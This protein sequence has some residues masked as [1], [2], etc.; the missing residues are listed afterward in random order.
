MTKSKSVRAWPEPQKISESDY[1]AALVPL[2]IKLVDLQ[3]EAMKKG[4]KVAIVFEGRDSAGK[5]GVIKRITEHLSLRQTRVIALP[6]PSDREK[7]QWWFQR[8][9]GHLPAA[10][11]I[12]I[13]NRSWYNRA[14]VERVMGFSTEEEQEIF[15]RDVADFERLLTHQGIVLIKYW[16]DITKDEQK[17]RLSERQS[18]PLKRLKVSAMDQIAVERFDAYSKARDE[19]LLRSHHDLGP[20]VCVRADNKRQTRLHLI[21]DLIHRLGHHAPELPS[22]CEDLVFSFDPDAIH[23]GRLAQ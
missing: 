11:E 14:G 4:L 5:D 21:Q 3:I 12:V 13:F 6:A 1:E 2:Q 17:K 19:M 15:L 22:P 7:S 18:D 9:V 16:L 23:D 10:G 20:W 8:Y